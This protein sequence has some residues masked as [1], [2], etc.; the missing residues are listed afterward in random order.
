MP[1]DCSCTVRVSAEKSTIDL[2]KQTEFSFKALHTPPEFP[3]VQDVSGQ[4]ERW[5]EWNCENWGTKWD[6]Y[7]FHIVQQGSRALQMNFTTAWGPPYA[8]FEYL[9]KKFPDLWLKCDWIEEGGQ[10][11]VFIGYTE[12]G[13]VKIKNLDWPDWCIEMYAH[14]FDR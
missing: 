3:P 6:R 9:L 5:Y 7:N 14:S 8:F 13:E 11:G 4:D 10:A 2:F 12:E 1:N